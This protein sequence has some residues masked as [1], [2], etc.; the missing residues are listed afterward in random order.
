MVAAS[1]AP[2]QSITQLTTPD[3][4][5]F[6]LCVDANVP[7]LQWAVASWADGADDPPG[8]PG[9]SRLVLRQSML[10]T[11]RSGSRDPEAER[12]ALAALDEA[13]QQFAQRPADPEAS[14]RV[15]D[16]D[17]AARSLADPTSFHRALAAL[18]VHRPEL[19]D[20]GA[21]G[22]L[23]LTT[24]PNAIADVGAMLVDRREE[25]AL[26]DLQRAW[27]DEL[28]ARAGG[29]GTDPFRPLL[30][31]LL[32]LAMPAHP[33]AGQLEDPLLTAPRRADALATWAATQHPQRTVHVLLGDF[34]AA[35]A[36]QVLQAT[37]VSTRLPA[38]PPP[39]PARGFQGQRRS[40]V[41]GTSS[42]MLVI[43]WP[44]PANADPT[45]LTLASQWLAGGAESRL[46]QLLARANR[47]QVQVDVRAPWPTTRDGRGL[48]VVTMREA[49]GRPGLAI[50]A[51]DACRD[52]IAG[53]PTDA[54]LQPLLAA[55]QRQWRDTSSD[56][57][58][59]AAAM[60]AAA[61]QWPNR[62]PPIRGPERVEPASVQAFLQA[63]LGGPSV[64]VE[65]QP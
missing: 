47:P 42:P 28:V 11:W 25:M 30:A 6:V 54:G 19:R 60:A 8:F 37:F 38:P 33:I 23:V 35:A 53:A 17:R 58:R 2:A 62:P 7:H 9:I 39:P 14:A 46:G 20:E 21:T 32:A 5:R 59:Q 3:G 34:D 50:A 49:G 31:E 27:S 13:W 1:L 15:V 43:A 63:T 22:V 61:L 55:L 26:R 18:P 41:P 16:L 65:G 36:A 44:I 64:L 24:L 40:V 51:L 57:R 52:A 29:P 4:S 10:G 48:F 45:T 12:R 56:P